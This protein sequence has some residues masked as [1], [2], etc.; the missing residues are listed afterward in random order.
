MASYLPPC[1]YRVP[2]AKAQ[3][4]HCRHCRVQGRPAEGNLNVVTDVQCLGCSERLRLCEEV[5]DEPNAAPS[6]V[7]M[8][9]NFAKAA[10]KHAMDG[11]RKTTPEERTNRL[12]ICSS[13]EFCESREEA[14]YRCT[15]C[16]C[17]LQ[18]KTAWASEHC[19]LAKW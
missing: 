15:N 18:V 5:R 11:A 6:A 13:C 14:P 8:A 16:G 2:L 4:H 9:L 12:A 10:A 3:H 7:E 19:P 1:Q 17:F